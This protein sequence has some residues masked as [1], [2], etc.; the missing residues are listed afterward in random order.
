M[1]H[2]VV[3]GLNFGDEGKGK[4]VD[5]LCKSIKDKGEVVDMVVRFSGG[6]QASHEVESNGHKHLFSH[7]GSGTLQGVPT[8]WSKYCP[9]DPIVLIREF[10]DLNSKGIEPTIFID[11]KCPITTPYEV[12]VS[13]TDRRPRLDGTCGAGVGQTIEREVNHYS[14]LFED[15]FFPTVFKQKVENIVKRYDFIYRIND[16]LMKEFWHCISILQNN[17]YLGITCNRRPLIGS[18]GHVIFEG[19]QGLMLDQNHGVF[20]HVTHSNTG[21]T[22]VL[23]LIGDTKFNLYLVS[24][25]YLTK[26]GAGNDNLITP[27][28]YV[29]PREHNVPNKF[30]GTLVTG[31]LDAELIRYAIKKHDLAKYRPTVLLTCMDITDNGWY[32]ILV[33]DGRYSTLSLY[34]EQN[35]DVFKSAFRIHTDLQTSSIIEL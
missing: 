8:Y 17:K 13:Q 9:V 25:S 30:Q 4:A 35:A 20:P 26:H 18:R 23:E 19:S 27:R 11:P 32:H 12:H 5:W 29:N 10:K 7:F 3:L 31:S 22:N 15:I 34:S 1:K 21:V 14:L 33:R 28:E 6:C 2:H 24:R 16:D